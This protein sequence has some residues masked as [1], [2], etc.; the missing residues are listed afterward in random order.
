LTNFLEAWFQVFPFRLAD[1][2]RL[3]RAGSDDAPL[4]IYDGRGKLVVPLP[5]FI[6]EKETSQA[7]VEAASKKKKEMRRHHESVDQ[8]ASPYALESGT[9]CSV[10][11]GLCTN[12]TDFAG[13]LKRIFREI[14]P[15]IVLGVSASDL[16]IVNNELGIVSCHRKIRMD[17]KWVVLAGFRNRKAVA[18]HR[19]SSQVRFFPQRRGIPIR[20]YQHE[21]RC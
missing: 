20:D 19:T 17:E 3:I 7:F 15:D 2:S 10:L 21:R 4:D 11:G 1:I 5:P 9:G 18:P 16:G 8:R 12:E 13:A 6:V 14:F